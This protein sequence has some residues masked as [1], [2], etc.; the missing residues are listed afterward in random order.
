MEGRPI[1]LLVITL[2]LVLVPMAGLAAPCDGRGT[3]VAAITGTDGTHPLPAGEVVTLR[4]QV[5]GAFLEG[6]DG[7]WLQQGQGQAARGVFVY[8]PGITTAEGS[9]PTE[10]HRVA[11]TAETDR[12]RGRIQLTDL[13][14][15]RDCGPATVEPVPLPWPATTAELRRR[16]G[17]RVELVPELVVSGHFELGRY[18]S[19]HLTRERLFHPANIP[20][21][22]AEPPWLVLDDGAYQRDPEPVPYL[23]EGGTRRLGSRV[24]ATG[25][26]TRAYDAWRLHPT[27]PPEFRRGERPPPPRPPP[28]GLRRVATLNLENLFHTLGERGAA[29]HD[30]R[31]H[32][33]GRLSAL[34]SRLRADVLALAELENRDAA[35]GLL[36]EG[37][38]TGQYRAVHPDPV[39]DDAIRN[40]LLYRDDRLERI[41]PAHTLEGPFVR[42]P[43]AQ[44]F[45]FTRGPESAAERERQSLAFT[46]VAVHLKS[47]AGCP[48]SGEDTDHGYGCWDRQRQRA[49]RAL[50]RAVEELEPPVIIAGDLNAYPSEPPV[51]ILREAGFTDRI[52]SDRPVAERYTYNWRGRSGQLDYLLTRGL[53]EGG[54]RVASTGIDRVNVDEP[55]VAR[56]G[57]QPWRASDHDP[58]WVDLLPFAGDE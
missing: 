41:G 36:L 30:A 51:A 17:T 34:V 7:F 26:L 48:E 44:R 40:A 8:A 15:L 56:R 45:R 50:A 22:P 32:Q 25:I 10:G 23:D 58:L 55:E 19:L 38:G 43:I 57:D 53:E 6:L 24:S 28:P 13:S 14:A 27:K 31:R 16:A 54:V 37:V 20:A 33:A 42:P 46:V 9:P 39:G 35:M 29:E 12:Y 5:A 1:P 3:A 21:G 49:A 47:K 2:C 18:G 52:Q 4:G 11:I